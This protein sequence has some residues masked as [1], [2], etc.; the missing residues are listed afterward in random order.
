MGRK[1]ISGDRQ[2]QSN[3]CYCLFG[4]SRL[5]KHRPEVSSCP[6]LQGLNITLIFHIIMNAFSQI[7]Q[8]QL[9]FGLSICKAL[10]VINPVEGSSKK[11]SG[12]YLLR[13]SDLGEDKKVCKHCYY[14]AGSDR[15]S[16]GSRDI[17]H[18]HLE[19]MYTHPFPCTMNGLYI[20]KASLVNSYCVSSVSL[21]LFNQMREKHSLLWIVAYEG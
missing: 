10:Y 5:G 13:I 18:K 20:S 11:M 17:K 3:W 19:T 6:N 9:Y 16:N 15:Y 7:K 1:T 4:R 2:L 12:S 21:S 14:K 8:A